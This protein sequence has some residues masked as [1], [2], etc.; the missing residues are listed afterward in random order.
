M[1]NVVYKTDLNHV[2]WVQVKAI[3][4][5]DDFDNGRSPEQLKASFENSYA[6]CLAYAE[7][8]IVGTARA[9]SDGVCNAYIV[10]VWTLSSFRQQGIAKTMMQILISKLQGQHVYLFTDDAVDFYKK[11][12][13]VEQPVGLSQVVGNWLV[14]DET[15]LVS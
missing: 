13:F 5:Q 15:S 8:Q 6:T 9:L 11:L 2:D 7:E 1:A 14:N 10:D 12:G 4:H 3:L